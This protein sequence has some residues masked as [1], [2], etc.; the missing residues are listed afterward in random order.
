MNGVKI[1]KEDSEETGMNE[2]TKEEGDEIGIE[3]IKVVIQ[4]MKKNESSRYKENIK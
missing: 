3:E 1:E 4:R 2:G